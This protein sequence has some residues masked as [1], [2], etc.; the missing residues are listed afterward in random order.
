MKNRLL[1]F[2]KVAVSLGL[3]AYVLTRPEILKADW[4]GMLASMRL[5]YWLL[6]LGVYCVAIGLN[7]K[8]WQILIR[9]LGIDAPYPSLFR[10]NLV[11]L[12]FANLP[13]SMVGGD[14]ARGWDLARTSA[15]GQAAP[16]AV[17]V[18]LDRLIGLAAFLVAA[19]AGLA[20]AT[21]AL[22]RADL[23]SLLTIMASILTGFV[24]AMAV[25]M[26][27]RLRALAERFL[28]LGPLPRVLPL[29]R[30][31]SDSVQVY[32]NRMSPLLVALGL[33]LATVLAT[34]LVNYLAAMATGAKVPPEW[35]LILTPLTPFALY[36]PSIASGLGVN[37][38]VF[39]LLYHDLA[40]VMSEPAALAFS[41]AM[42]LIIVASSLPGAVLWWR[43]R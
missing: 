13:L 6:A 22:G 15:S 16:V 27:Q 40:G 39:G 28:G 33:G 25:L 29:F 30:K 14:I 24:V 38:W 4:R 37:Q 42:Q 23:R 5:G 8:K 2:F 18:L 17:S 32:R 34:C 10:H 43:R 26:S 1:T 11:G 12:F 35:V 41:L 7:V 19:T 21:I 9:A 20:Y 36:I 3:L 31:L